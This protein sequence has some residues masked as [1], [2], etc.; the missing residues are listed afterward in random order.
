MVFPLTGQSNIKV[1]FDREGFYMPPVSYV[2][3]SVP[4]QDKCG[5]VSTQEGK[6][7]RRLNI[8]P[9]EIRFRLRVTGTNA[10][11]LR[12]NIRKYIRAFSPLYGE[13]KL[14]VTTPDGLVR[15]LNARYLDGLKLQETPDETTQ[16]YQS[17]PVVLIAYDPYWYADAATSL[18]LVQ[19]TESTSFFPFFPLTLNNASMFADTVI[20]NDGDT[21][22]YPIWKVYGP[23]EYLKFDN[24]TTGQKII[25][26]DPD[27]MN[28][29]VN[30]LSSSQYLT[31]DCRPGNFKIER[32]DGKN[33]FEYTTPDSAL[34]SFQTG[35]N[36]IRLEVSGPT[37]ETKVDLT[38][39]KRYLV[40]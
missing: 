26:N 2:E 29:N 38:Y 10:A 12:Q 9:R 39:Q 18:T 22:A 11:N 20:D 13:G 14:E 16:T 4:V 27:P 25:I 30:L 15:Y 31:I 19:N 37:S 40:I 35:S 24:L 36:K 23:A 1:L 6:T 34:F 32:S 5:D 28:S 33:M 3:E 17:L 7:V 21:V 8:E